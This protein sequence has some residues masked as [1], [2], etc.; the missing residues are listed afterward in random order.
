MTTA[1]YIIWALIP[2]IYFLLALWAILEKFGDKRKQTN[3]EA[4]D[5][6][7]Q[8]GIVSIFVAICFIID[9]FFLE[10]TLAPLIPS[11]IPIELIRILLLPL[12]FLIGSHAL[13]GTEPER[14][15]HGARNSQSKKKKKKK[16]KK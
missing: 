5:L 2:I 1:L 12:V 11:F 14:V 3:R 13:G 10:S 6:F 15:M 16:R 4:A 7:K 8:L 9:M